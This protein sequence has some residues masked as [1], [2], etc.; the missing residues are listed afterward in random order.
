MRE[1][2]RPHQRA[3]A[4]GLPARVALLAAVVSEL[5]DGRVLT[6]PRDVLDAILAHAFAGHPEISC[7]MVAGPEDSGRPDRFIPMENAEHS[8]TFWRFEAVEQFRV[9]REMDARGEEPVIIYHSQANPDVRPSAT[10]IAHAGEPRAHYMVVSTADPDRPRYGVFRIADGRATE[11]EVVVGD[12]RP[13]R[14]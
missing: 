6:I 9:M 11:V 3:P 10:T 7:G 8:T 1:G 4:F 2:R 5:F 13:G 14:G 12:A